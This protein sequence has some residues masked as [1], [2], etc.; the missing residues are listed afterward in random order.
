MNKNLTF[1]KVIGFYA[2]TFFSCGKTG[3]SNSSDLESIRQLMTQDMTAAW[4]KNDKSWISSN[5]LEDAD[6]AFPSGSLFSGREN[7]PVSGADVP[8][9]RKFHA[10]I[11]SLRFISPDVALVNNQAHFTGGTNEQGQPIADLR[12]AG[13]FILKKTEGKWKIA[14][15]RV[16]PMRFDPD[17]AKAEIVKAL[18]D[19][20]LAWKKGDAAGSVDL[21]TEDAINYRPDAA[22]DYGRSAILKMSEGWL[23]NNTIRELKFN[24]QELDIIGDQAYELGTFIQD[25]EP[26]N[27]GKPLMQ[28]GRYFATWRFDA[29]GQWRIDRFIFNNAP[30]GQ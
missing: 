6:V 12:D 2:L 8:T 18:D 22:P 16:L 15:L 9:G 13:T 11:Q 23:Q 25:I 21:F 30:A 24:S 29:D 28:Q 4:E 5:Y 20:A 19:F 1:I 17:K 3:D 7:L 27:G 26:K 10:E 14:A